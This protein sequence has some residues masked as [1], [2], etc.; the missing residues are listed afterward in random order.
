MAAM[1]CAKGIVKAI[2]NENNHKYVGGYEL[3]SILV[4]QLFPKTFY[5]LMRKMTKE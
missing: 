2:K 5:K 4:K 1:D 3:F